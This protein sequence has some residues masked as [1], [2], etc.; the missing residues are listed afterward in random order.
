ME[1]RFARRSAPGTVIVLSELPWF[2]QE[3]F[4]SNF[5]YFRNFLFRGSV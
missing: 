4:K 1:L 5:T 3:D 2:M